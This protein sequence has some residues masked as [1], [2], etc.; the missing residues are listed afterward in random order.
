[1][2]WWMG[3]PAWQSVDTTSKRSLM[4]VFSVINKMV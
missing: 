1:L 3:S 4:I 2:Y